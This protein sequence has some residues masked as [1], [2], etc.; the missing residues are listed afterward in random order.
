MP[1]RKRSFDLAR[2]PIWKTSCGHVSGSSSSPPAC[3]GFAFV[4]SRFTFAR[5]G[6]VSCAWS[7]GQVGCLRCSIQPHSLF[8][9]VDSALV[10]TRAS[11]RLK[12]K[13][14]LS[15]SLLFH[16]VLYCV[17]FCALC[18]VCCS[19]NYANNFNFLNS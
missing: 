11:W 4:R 13:N 5:R 17:F 6:I 18:F 12:P 19:V 16:V 14:H 7:L 8:W 3:F 9:S 15:V 10:C 2:A 1:F